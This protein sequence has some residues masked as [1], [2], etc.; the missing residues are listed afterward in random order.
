MTEPDDK[1]GYDAPMTSKKDAQR[2]G[3]GGVLAFA[4]MSFL[5]GFIG[6]REIPKAGPLPPPPPAVVFVVQTQQEIQNL[7]EIVRSILK[8]AADKKISVEQAVV[9]ISAAFR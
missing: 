8:N 5:A 2:L 3:K 1:P 9:Q 6:G 7:S 4:G